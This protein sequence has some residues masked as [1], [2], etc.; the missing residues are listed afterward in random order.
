MANSTYIRASHAAL[1][2]CLT[3][4]SVSGR[5]WQ[6][7]QETI[8]LPAPASNVQPT[9]QTF[10]FVSDG[11]IGPGWTRPNEIA[12]TYFHE[13]L[14]AL[15][16]RTITLSDDVPMQGKLSWIFTGPHA[17]FTVELTP[18]KV[19]LFQRFYDSSALYTGQ[20]NYPRRSFAT[21]SNSSRATRE[22][23]PLYSIRISLCR[24]C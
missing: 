20:G 9:A 12:R 22:H 1:I 2:G 3:L 19:R 5:S 24:S 4:L 8:K 10:D 15:F 21:M 13:E 23:L 11:P 18:S 17:G 6:S 7:A 14:P 16:R